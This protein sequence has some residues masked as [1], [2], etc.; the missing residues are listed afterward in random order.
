LKPLV[1]G[2]IGCSL[3]AFWQNLGI[4]LS[5]VAATVER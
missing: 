1:W 5:L 2:D 3:S 4:T